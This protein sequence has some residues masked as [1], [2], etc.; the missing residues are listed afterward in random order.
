MGLGGVQFK[1]NR[2]SNAVKSAGQRYAPSRVQ[3]PEG[4]IQKLASQ[5]PP[6]GIDCNSL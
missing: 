2:F 6:G 5:L 3:N 4:L 1:P